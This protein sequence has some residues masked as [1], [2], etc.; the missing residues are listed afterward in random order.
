L[1]LLFLGTG[2]GMPAKARN[3]SSIAL[4]LLEERKAVWL[5]DCGEA[6]QHQILYTA[7]KPR[8]IEKIFITHMHGDHIFGL[9][10]FLGSRSFQGGEEPLTIYGPAG[11][12]E[13][14]QS[15]LQLSFTHLKYPLEIVEIDEGLVFEDEQFTVEAK[16]LEHGVPSYGYRITEK[17]APGMLL[18]DKL[19]EA[20]VGPGPVY[21]KLK[22]GE[23]VQL[24]DGRV[25]SGAD[26]LGA[27]KKGRV[28]ALLGDT[29]TCPQILDLARNA[30]MLVHEATFGEEDELLAYQYFHSSTTQAAAAALEANAKKLVLTHIS[31]RYQDDDKDTLLSEAASIFPNTSVAEDFSSFEVERAND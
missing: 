20:G 21:K 25:L 27:P 11:I 19:K 23:T 24:E 16:K 6:T 3:V 4:R 8:K 22:D 26:F 14:V 12:K 2:A 15:S 30:D 9:P 28:V 29:R 18:V 5:F 13:Y 17:D 10:G 1:D 31:A 7:I